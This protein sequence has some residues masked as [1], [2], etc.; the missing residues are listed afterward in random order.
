MPRTVES[1]VA[2][3]R[4]AS[5]RRRVGRPS[6][7]L[8]LRLKDVL[9][10][11]AEA[12]DGLTA[13]QAVEMSHKIG[14]LLNVGVPAAWRTADSDNYSMDFEDLFERFEQV[15]LS[16]F[17]ATKEWPDSPCEVINAWL[18]ELYDWGDRHR[19]WLG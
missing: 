1:I 7:A 8:T 9:A 6:W 2:C 17:T 16:D 15:G 13:E 19:V 3:H 10:Q 12:G 11:Y 18:D 4:E 14:L 5:A